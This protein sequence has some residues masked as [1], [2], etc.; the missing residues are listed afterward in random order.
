MGDGP[1]HGLDDGVT[2]GVEEE[3]LLVDAETRRTVPRAAAVLARVPKPR[4]APTPGGG[5]YEE[6][7]TAQVEAATGICTTL[8]A[9]RDHLCDGRR[10]LAAA[11]SGEDAR[12]ISS[13]TAVLPGSSIPVTPGERFAEIADRYAGVVTDYQTCGCHVHTGVADRETAVAV[14]NHLRPWLPTLVALAANSPFDHG[15]DSGYASWRMLEQARFPGSGVPPSFPSAA[16]YDR[17]VALL[18]EAGAL[19]DER[20]SFWLAR[21]SPRLPT[22]EVRAGDAAA[23]VDE[24]ILQAAL[25]RALVRTA[26]TDLARGREAPAVGDQL[27]AAATWTAARYGLDGPGVHPIEERAVPAARLLREM[28]DRVRPALEASGDLARVH[29]VLAWL[30]RH[31]GGASRQRAAAAH[32]SEAVVDLLAEQTI[33][34]AEAPAG[35]SSRSGRHREDEDLTESS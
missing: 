27:C 14:V 6:L 31:G 35:L 32:G 11:A 16:A 22:V 4:V 18:V 5:L 9:L 24:A 25:V 17:Q 15:R 8:D 30:S 1:V 23:T 26:L 34:A 12:L 13:G 3:F 10:R 29:A 7:L 19:I 2:V 33:A 28:L 20:M 21:P